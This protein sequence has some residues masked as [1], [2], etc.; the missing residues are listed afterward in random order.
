ME[1]TLNKLSVLPNVLILDPIRESTY[2]IPASELMKFR[3]AFDTPDIPGG[4]TVTFYI[5][6]EH[7]FEV[8]QPF[9]SPDATN[10]SVLIQNRR[11]NASYFLSHESLQPF[12]VELPFAL[13]NESSISFTIPIGGE[14]IQELSTIRRVGASELD[15]EC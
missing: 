11:D 9:C 12:R 10:P 3:A 14:I 8:T 13:P 6:Q 15:C 7:T 4:D 5:Q 2:Y 1:N